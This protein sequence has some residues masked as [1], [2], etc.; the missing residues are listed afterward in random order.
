VPLLLLMG[1]MRNGLPTDHAIVIGGRIAGLT[2]ARV[3][4]RTISIR[5]QVRQYLDSL[6]SDEQI[7]CVRRWRLSH[8]AVFL[9]PRLHSLP[10]IR[11]LHRSIT[12][13]VVG[14]EAVR[15]VRINHNLRR[16]AGGLEGDAHSFNF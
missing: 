12:R 1:K 15:C 3:C 16:L 5:L 6:E 13:P 4:S 2:A 10:A 11:S 7:H 9:E 14:I 8:H